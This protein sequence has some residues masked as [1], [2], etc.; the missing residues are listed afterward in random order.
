M[1]HT[2]RTYLSFYVILLTITTISINFGG[3]LWDFV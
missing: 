3:T 1:L 2:Q